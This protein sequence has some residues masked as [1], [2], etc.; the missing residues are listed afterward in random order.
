MVRL[1]SLSAELLIQIFVESG[2]TDGIWTAEVDQYIPE[3]RMCWVLAARADQKSVPA[4][5]SRDMYSLATSCK[6]LYNVFKANEYTIFL[7]LV[8]RV[9]VEFEPRM[10][11]EPTEDGWYWT[12][13]MPSDW[14]VYTE[15]LCLRWSVARRL[16]RAMGAVVPKMMTWEGIEAQTALWCEKDVREVIKPEMFGW[17]MGAIR[18][19]IRSDYFRKLRSSD[20]DWD[21]YCE[22]EFVEELY[23]DEETEKESDENSN[24]ES[25]EDED[26]NEG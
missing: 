12:H 13:H 3:S 24:E 14:F 17:I 6:Y 19:R 9:V 11:Y 8:K 15:V 23:S 25:D 4:R 10:K 2:A 26:Q 18:E 1:T 22:E 5:K 20:P 16:M 21:T 7:E